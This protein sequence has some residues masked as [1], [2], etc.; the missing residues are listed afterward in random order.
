MSSPGE[1]E[2]NARELQTELLELQLEKVMG[3][4]KEQEED[5]EGIK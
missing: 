1:G 5:E 3:E 4:V 2:N